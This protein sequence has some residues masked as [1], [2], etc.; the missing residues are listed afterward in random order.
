MRSIAAYNNKHSSIVP[1]PA[2]NT[3]K[4]N[5]LC[6]AK[7]VPASKAQ[8]G[9]F[10]LHGKNGIN[11]TA[12]PFCWE[13]NVSVDAMAGTEQAK[14]SKSGIVARPSKPIGFKIASHKTALL[15]R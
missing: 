11:V 15:H 3:M 6:P 8:S 9:I 7:S 10:A 1:K 12:L 2:T 14:P 5:D 4:N 13:R